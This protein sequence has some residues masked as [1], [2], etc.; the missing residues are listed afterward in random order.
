MTSLSQSD[1]Q[2]QSLQSSLLTACNVPASLLE[3]LVAIAETLSCRLPSAGTF[4]PQSG[5]QT[6]ILRQALAQQCAPSSV[7]SVGTLDGNATS[8]Q[9]SQQLGIAQRGR[10]HRPG[11]KMPSIHNNPNVWQQQSLEGLQGINGLAGQRPSSALSRQ[12][13]G[14]QNSGH[15]HSAALPGHDSMM[16]DRTRL[17]PW[18]SAQQPFCQQPEGPQHLHDAAA[19]A[20]SQQQQRP[21]STHAGQPPVRSFQ[22]PPPHSMHVTPDNLAKADKHRQAD[23]SSANGLQQQ[24]ASAPWLST[25]GSVVN[26]EDAFRCKLTGS[27]GWRM[28]ES[29]RQVSVNALARTPFGT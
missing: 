28:P 21:V 2:S 5:H 6:E 13:P 26:D 12:R 23:G 29:K 9:S 19:A 8:L 1:S 15:S 24:G 17:Q 16:N 18:Q 14:M 3:G 10:G 7:L 11:M 22:V 27:G 4:H 20:Y 25:N